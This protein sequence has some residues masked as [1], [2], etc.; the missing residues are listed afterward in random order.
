VVLFSVILDGVLDLY[1]KS[2][3]FWFVLAGYPAAI[4]QQAKVG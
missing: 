3:G 4:W 2:V 1:D